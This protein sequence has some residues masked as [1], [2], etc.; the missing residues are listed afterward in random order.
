MFGAPDA[1]WG[2]VVAV[3]VVPRGE[4]QEDETGW[5][6][7]LSRRARA[8]ADYKKPRRV[9]LLEALPRTALGKVQKTKLLSLLDI[10]T[11]SP[12]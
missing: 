8:L 12:E 3:A 9:L 11:A 7:R 6:E 5:L 1:R 2:Q 4:V 10:H